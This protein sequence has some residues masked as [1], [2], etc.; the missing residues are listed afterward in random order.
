MAQEIPGFK[1][2]YSGKVRDLY[3]PNEN[4]D[5]VLVVASDRVSAFDHVLEP[6]ISNKGKYLTE[7]TNWWFAHLPTPNHVSHEL[8]IPKE[9]QQRGTICKKLEMFPIECVVRGYISGS[10]WKE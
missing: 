1:H 7:L 4:K 8:A 9:V 10:G 5:L 3:E 2:I 6:A